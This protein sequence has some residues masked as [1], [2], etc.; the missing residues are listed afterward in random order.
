MPAPFLIAVGAL[1]L[2]EI[3]IGPVAGWTS[4]RTP[5]LALPLKAPLSTLN[6]SVLLPFRVV[7]RQTLEAAV[8][9]ALGT[10]QYIDWWLE[11]STASANNP[12]RYAHL[13]ITYDSGGK[14][15]VPH[16][17]DECRLGAG[18][19]FAREPENHEIP[20]SQL[21]GNQ[22]KARVRL[23]TFLKTAVFNSQEDSVVY[24]FCANGQIV[25]TRNDVRLVINDPKRKYAYF[26]KVELSFPRA[27]REQTLSGATSV[28]NVLLPALVRDHWPDID[29][30]EAATSAATGK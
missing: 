4:L 18:Y 22:L 25:A 29:A 7:E 9:D 23:C 8:V 21:P 10:D 17:P 15:L 26:S 6:E 24:T 14:N 20:L 12:L 5:K 19:Q 13:F 16:T 11:N 1:T 28:L 30:A 27:T 3:V 2:T